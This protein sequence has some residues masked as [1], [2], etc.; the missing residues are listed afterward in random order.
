MNNEKKKNDILKK[1][2]KSLTNFQEH[3]TTMKTHTPPRQHATHDPRG[4]PQ[5]HSLL[6]KLNCTCQEPSSETCWLLRNNLVASPT[7]NLSH[8]TQLG[9]KEKIAT[10]D[11]HTHTHTHW[12]SQLGHRPSAYKD[13]HLASHTF[14]Q[15]QQKKE[16]KKKKMTTEK[17]R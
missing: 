16:K 6:L 14:D 8:S 13:I 2:E 5:E 15:T 10:C 1:K 17:E 12:R 11:T 3:T 4:P 7:A 9:E